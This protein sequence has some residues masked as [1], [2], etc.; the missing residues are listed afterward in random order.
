MTK[1]NKKD[2]TRIREWALSL[3]IYYKQGAGY[4]GCNWGRMFIFNMFGDVLQLDLFE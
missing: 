3:D 2:I 4:G 1:L